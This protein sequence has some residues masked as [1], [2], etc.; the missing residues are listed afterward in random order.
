MSEKIPLSV[1]V[2][3]RNEEKNIAEC[4][5]SV[6]WAKD[7]IVLDDQS[8]D[9]T[10]EIARTYTNHIVQR[11]MDI[12][13][14]H[15]NVGYSLAKEEWILSLDADERVT[16]ELAREIQKILLHPSTPHNGFAIP[17]KNYLGTY[18]IQHG[19]WYPSG[20]LKLFRKNKFRYREDEVHCFPELEG[21]WG[22]LKGDIVHYSYKDFQDFIHKLNNQSTREAQK[23]IRTG[24]KVSLFTAL[25]RTLDRFFRS[26]LLKK[27]YKDGFIGF[28]V[29]IFASLYQ[30]A[31]YAKYWE[32]KKNGRSP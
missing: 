28:M 29:A 10:L 26:Y 8:T 30:I 14:R 22:L 12:E 32:M 21:S 27:G 11:P 24:R 5:Q 6:S 17:R 13:G 19:G 1:M 3:T 16:P 25:W 7:I 23:W 15:R 4:L 18:W 20:Q 9:K 31:S 2:L